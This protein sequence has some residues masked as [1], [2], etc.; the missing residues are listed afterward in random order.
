MQAN[1]SPIDPLFFLHHANIDRLWDVWTRKQQARGYPVLPE[2]SDLQAWSS[3]PFLFFV[4]SK[5]QSVTKRIAGDYATIGDF[6]YDYQPGSGEQVVPM[7]LAAPAASVAVT[8]AERFSAQ[9][10]QSSISTTEPAV[11]AVTIPYAL[12]QAGCNRRRPGCLHR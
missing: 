2:G 9:I 3:E 12:L 4:D 8:Q 7:T 5:G 1:L 6:N 10:S 11:G